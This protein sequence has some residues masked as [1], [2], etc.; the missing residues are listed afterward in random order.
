MSLSRAGARSQRRGGPGPPGRGRGP[1]RRRRRTRGPGGGGRRGAGAG[2]RGGR[3]ACPAHSSSPG[4]R[5]DIAGGGGCGGDGHSRMRLGGGST[6]WPF[7]WNQQVEEGSNPLV[8]TDWLIGAGTGYRLRAKLDPA[9]ANTSAGGLRD[10]SAEISILGVRPP[11]WPSYGISHLEGGQP[12]CIYS[13][14]NGPFGAGTGRRLAFGGGSGFALGEVV[15]SPGLV[16]C[17]YLISC[18]LIYVYK[19][20]NI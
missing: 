18:L 11:S 13:M 15:F 10:R 17:M 4:A 12:P 16:L 9:G 3:R 14:V 7:V 6:P 2:M 19:L 1:L 5:G 20:D 8:L